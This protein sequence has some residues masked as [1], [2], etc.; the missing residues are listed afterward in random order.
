MLEFIKDRLECQGAPYLHMY[1]C[2]HGT[3]S[4]NIPCADGKTI[5]L[6]DIVMMILDTC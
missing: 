2:G 4:G 5:C 3:K 6:K 1:Y